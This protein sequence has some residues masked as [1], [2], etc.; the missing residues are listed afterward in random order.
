MSDSQQSKDNERLVPELDALF[1]DVDVETA[2][3]AAAVSL[4]KKAVA[5]GHP[6]VAAIR[7]IPAIQTLD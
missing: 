2:A 4:T 1:A 6:Y 7:L 5:E 3:M